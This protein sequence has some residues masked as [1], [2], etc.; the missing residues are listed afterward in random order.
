MPPLDPLRQALQD[1]VRRFLA[2]LVAE[3][4]ST[5]PLRAMLFR[6]AEVAREVLALEA[7]LLPGTLELLGETWEDGGTY[8]AARALYREG[9]LAAVVSAAQG[10]EEEGDPMGD[11]VWLSAAE[12]GRLAELVRGGP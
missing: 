7:S 1:R 3:G 8:L 4:S 2:E 10:L 12:L 6:G 5:A 9:D 11:V